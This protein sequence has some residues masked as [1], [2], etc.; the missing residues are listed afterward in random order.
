MERAVNIAGKWS[1]FLFDY[2]GRIVEK[3]EDAPEAYPNDMRETYSK[4]WNYVS[5][6]YFGKEHVYIPE[7]G[8]KPWLDK[9]ADEI[10][11]RMG[12]RPQFYSY[13][14]TEDEQRHGRRSRTNKA[15]ADQLLGEDSDALAERYWQV[16][17]D[18]VGLPNTVK[19]PMVSFIKKGRRLDKGNVLFGE[20]CFLLHRVTVSLHHNAKACRVTLLHELCHLA[21]GVHHHHDAH[22]N[23]CL[24]NAANRIWGIKVGD[25]SS[26]EGYAVTDLIEAL[27]EQQ[28]H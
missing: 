18:V 16:L 3:M 15:L 5:A 7:P 19:C 9:L 25:P 28:E 8:H 13:T 12:T 1:S 27:L 2:V 21:V 22:Y 26:W 24:A 6:A 14:L 17:L 23:M 11:Q 4:F 10:K 20:A